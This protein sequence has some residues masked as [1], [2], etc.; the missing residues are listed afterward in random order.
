MT[1]SFWK[2]IA[3]FNIARQRATTYLSMITF[4][5]MLKVFLDSFQN[6]TL[7]EILLAVGL[8]MLIIIT[9]ID[10][11]FILP[12]EYG[13]GLERNVEWNKVMNKEKLDEKTA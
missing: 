8:I 3:I 6:K 1:T 4:L 2:K 10:F 9:I 5:M 11:K 7:G 13:I 12:H